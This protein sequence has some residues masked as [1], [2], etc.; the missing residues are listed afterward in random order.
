VASFVTFWFNH[1]YV[2]RKNRLMPYLPDTS[3]DN[4]LK[5]ASLLLVVAIYFTIFY[6]WSASG[7]I[8]VAIVWESLAGNQGCFYLIIFGGVIFGSITMEVNAPTDFVF[9]I[10]SS[11]LFGVAEY[12]IHG[13]RKSNTYVIVNQIAL[14]GMVGSILLYGVM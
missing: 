1:V 11:V 14:T 5:I 4:R 7:G 8:L 6:G 12:L 10:V 2:L 3:K 13:L 9:K